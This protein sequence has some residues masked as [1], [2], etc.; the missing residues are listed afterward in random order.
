MPRVSKLS[1]Q[2]ALVLTSR[3]QNWAD[4]SSFPCSEVWTSQPD[5]LR[6]SM[7]KRAGHASISEIEST[8]SAQRLAGVSDP[9]RPSA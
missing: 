4:Y 2:I 3:P 7:V 9:S 5:T 8:I 1:P 6:K